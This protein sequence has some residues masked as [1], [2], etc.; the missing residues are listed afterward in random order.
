MVIVTKLS[1]II[2]CFNEEKTIDE[3]VR[4]VEAAALPAGWEKEV[5]LVDDFSTDETRNKI[6]EYSQKHIVVLR[7]KN[8]GKGAAVKS[9]LEKVTGDF[10]LI[11]DA[12]LEY[13]PD[14]YQKLV[15]ALN[16]KCS[17][18]FGSRLRQENDYFSLVYLYGSEVLT[19]VFNLFFRSKFTDITTC[20]KLFP[21]EVI[22]LLL[23]WPENDF[24][25][26]AV[27]LTYELNKFNP[28]IVEIPI[29]YSPRGREEGKKVNWRH[30][31]KSL[32]L[33]MEIRAGKHWQLFKFLVT[34]GVAL[35]VNISTLYLFTSVL[36]IH[37]LV[38]SICSFSVA[39]AVNFMLQKFWTFGHTEGNIYREATSF[40]V[41]QIIVNLFLNTALLYSLVEYLHIYYLLSQV[42]VSLVLAVVTFFIAKKYI[43]RPVM[44][45]E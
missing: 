12:D 16:E 35:V 39:V 28:N 43:F 37:Y 31:L 7:E 2:P 22:P 5:I 10:V 40:L 8:G 23:L 13:N 4:R 1:V 45:Q 3:I 36:G 42:V 41:L 25:F 17:I 29:R 33:M 15:G 26:D 20:Y 44:L 9:G 6:S 18:V 19:H 14:D 38:S 30:G 21:R 24:V 34:G 11:Q 32:L 27:C